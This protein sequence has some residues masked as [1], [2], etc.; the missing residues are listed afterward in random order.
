MGYQDG[1]PSSGERCGEVRPAQGEFTDPVG[2]HVDNLPGSVHLVHPIEQVHGRVMSGNDPRA[3][4]FVR[5]SGLHVVVDLKSLSI[6]I[7]KVVSVIGDREAGDR[8]P[9]GGDSRGVAAGEGEPVYVDVA[10]VGSTP[11]A[12]LCAASAASSPV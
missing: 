3:D 4:D 10:A 2:I 1:S 9:Q 6:K 7:A 12:A 5:T 11:F 8:G